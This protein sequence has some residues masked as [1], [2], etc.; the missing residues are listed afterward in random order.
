[1]R[2]IHQTFEQ[3]VGALRT[4]GGDYRVERLRPFPGFG[5]IQILVEDVVEDIHGVPSAR[6]RLGA[7][8]LVFRSSRASLAMPEGGVDFLP[9]QGLRPL[10]PWRRAKPS[11]L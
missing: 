8:F 4:V 3:V 11:A 1:T 9:A 7:G 2:R 5:R 6:L 10:G